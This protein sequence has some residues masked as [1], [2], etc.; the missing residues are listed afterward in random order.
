MNSGVIEE[1][2]EENLKVPKMNMK[3]SLL[4]NTAKAALRGSL[5]LWELTLKTKTKTQ[6]IGE[7]AQQLRAPAVLPEPWV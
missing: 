1:M 5:Q 2:R 4:L 7:M 6:S 3:H